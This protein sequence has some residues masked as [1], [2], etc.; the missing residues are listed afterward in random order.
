MNKLTALIVDD[1]PDSVELLKIHLQKSCPH[2]SSHICFTSSIEA[3]EYLHEYSVPDILF[4]D[5]EM[6]GMNGFE[7]L[8]KLMPKRFNTIFITAYNQY[9]S[10]AFRFNAL[11]YLL[12]PIDPDQLRDAVN[13]V[14]QQS[15]PETVQIRQLQK[16]LSGNT[17]EIFALATQ[18]GV[19]FINLNDIILAE[20]INNYVKFYL[21]SGKSVIA[22][23]NLKE[24]QELLESYN[25]LRVHR[26]YII[27]LKKIKKYLQNDGLLSMNNDMEIPVARPQRQKLKSFFNW[28]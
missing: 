20:A 9:A 22:S 21:D 4:L 26:S 16:M 12:K 7:L 5:I 18:S 6:P 14:L 10:K 15:Q 17:P 3:Y 11:D 8:E 25:F 23:R 28:I 19:I 2:I 24:L 13:K 27:N 1:E